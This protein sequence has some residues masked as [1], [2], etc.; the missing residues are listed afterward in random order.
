MTRHR[1]T[2]LLLAVLL[3]SPFALRA[4]DSSL[5][6]NI[7]KE[8]KIRQL[9]QL[10]GAGDIGVQAMKEMVPA[11]QSLV[12]DAPATFWDDFIKEA[13]PE[14]L[15]ALTVPIYAR[16]FEEAEVDELIAFY[17]SPV[18]KKITREL[19]AIMSESMAAG[20]SWGMELARKAI[21]RA[22]D[23]GYHPKS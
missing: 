9:L 1:Q 2:L 3:A 8:T 17:S 20:Q 19:P 12:P 10:T 13:R 18:G 6:A 23:A 5:A 15:V 11:L 16:H 4:Q 14:E 7:S 21:E 22:R